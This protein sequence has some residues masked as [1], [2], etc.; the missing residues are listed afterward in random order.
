MTHFENMRP[1]KLYA[2]KLHRPEDESPQVIDAGAISRQ[3]FS[4]TLR[5]IAIMWF[6]PVSYHSRTLYITESEAS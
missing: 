3:V 5:I 4:T 2:K 1:Y 6:S